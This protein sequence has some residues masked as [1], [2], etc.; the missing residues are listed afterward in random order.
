MYV[1]SKQMEIEIREKMRGGVGSVQITHITKQSLPENARLIA[2]LEL[3]PGAS[4]GLHEH[5]EETEVFYFIQGEG[6]LNDNGEIRTVK[7][8]DAVLT[9]DGTAHS[10]ENTGCKTL[11]FLAIIITKSFKNK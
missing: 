6:T 10:I 9:G 7:A 5:F 2:R 1:E 3:E 8:G 11:E 4:I